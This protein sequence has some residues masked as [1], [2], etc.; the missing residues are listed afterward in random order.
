MS[1]DEKTSVGHMPDGKWAFD[2]DV[3]AVFDD[4]IERSIPQY[5]TMRAACNEITNHVLGGRHANVV[6][7]LG[8]S[9]GL[10][11]RD[12]SASKHAERV[13]GVEV[14]GPMLDVVRERFASYA[15]V[16]ILE[17][18]LRRSFPLVSDVDIVTSVFTIQFIP[19]E[20][21]A[22]LIRRIYDAMRPGGVFLVVEKVL[23]SSAFT[24]D[25]FVS[26]YHAM[27]EQNGYSREAIERKALSLEGALVPM[28]E[29]ANVAM[30]EAE[31]FR[32]ESFWR[33]MNF[34]GWVAQKPG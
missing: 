2:A 19:V 7:D 27:K 34:M 13:I 3:T 15:N 33:W 9:S 11:I 1:E 32:V 17:M 23:G 4:M 6:L 8:C 5:A 10:A 22:R 31:G 18:D 29:R 12:L 21:R 28:T 24:Q 20:Y 25:T 14:S 30:L 16:Q 26:L